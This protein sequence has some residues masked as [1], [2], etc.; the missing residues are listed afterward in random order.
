MMSM[1]NAKSAFPCRQYVTLPFSWATLQFLVIYHG[2]PFWGCSGSDLSLP[3]C[4]AA[5]MQ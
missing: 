4:H 2:A 3:A 5:D 1:V